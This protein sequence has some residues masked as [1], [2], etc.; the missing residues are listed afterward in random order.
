MNRLKKKHIFIPAIIAIVA[1]TFLV[2]YNLAFA[3]NKSESYSAFQTD[4]E[5]KN[6]ATVYLTDTSK[7]K[8]KL[9][10]GTIYSTDNPRSSDFK[11]SLLSDGINV[12]ENSDYSL[13]EI[14]LSL[15]MGLSLISV[16]FILIK[17]SKLSSNK[18]GVVDTVDVSAGSRTK[19]TFDKVAGNEEAKESVKDIVDFLKNPEKYSVYG[20]RMPKGII[21]YGEPGTG[22]TLLAKAVAGEAGVPFFAMSGSDFVQVY[23]GVGA[24]RI[25]NL[26]KKARSHGKAVIFID[27]IDAIG[28]KRDSGRS[29]GND[30]RDQTLN[31]LLTEMSGF[32]ESEGIVVIAATN[33]LDMLDSALL[34]PG[35]FDRHIE[36]TLPDV[37]AR[38]KILN[39]HLKNKPVKDI[40]V[41]DWAHSTA[42]FSGAKIESL[43]NEAAI[44][45]CKDMSPFITSE[46]MDK[47]F[48]IV[49]A[50]HEKI[51]RGHIKEKDLLIT[52]YHECGHA[53]VSLLKLPNEKVSKVTIIPSTKGA[54]GYTMS[55][56]ED[57][58]YHD[59]DYLRRRIMV[60]LGG[61]AA[62][63]L[64]LGKDKITTGAYGDLQHSTNLVTKMVT[65]YGMGESLG[66]LNLNELKNFIS[67]SPNELVEECK[68][69][70]SALYEDTLQLLKSNEAL[71]KIMAEKLLKKETLY[72]EELK[73][74]ISPAAVYNCD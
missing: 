16:L 42:Y 31:A 32:N 72:F 46:Y 3:S 58:M 21:L 25:R 67:P 48:S 22:K 65:Q 52:S 69:I 36:V 19:Y 61:R 53:L 28:K 10:D 11:Q 45:A 40:D 70:V 66:L 49:V 6:V 39:L 71:L 47:A 24:G 63:E 29:G 73:E 2:I 13:P 33:R 17:T 41:K 43:V 68:N 50:G 57:L 60:M 14:A 35:R 12:D 56:P 26:F 51:D 7:I 74:I 4:V 5:N 8:V 27:E 20:A 55:I 34:R 44:L 1:M 23:V 59:L 30:E 64:T 62:E 9:K 38:E 54:G 18:L 15:V 37:S